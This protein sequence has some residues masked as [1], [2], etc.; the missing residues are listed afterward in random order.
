MSLD[1]LLLVLFPFPAPLQQIIHRIFPLSSLP[2]PQAAQPTSRGEGDGLPLPFL[3][4]W[5]AP[6]ILFICL[7]ASIFIKSHSRKRFRLPQQK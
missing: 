1:F 5:T 6:M 2:R 7:L 4:S 3:W